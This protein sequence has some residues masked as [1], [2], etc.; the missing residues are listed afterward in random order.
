[1]TTKTTRLTRQAAAERLQVSESTLDRMVRRGDL[2]TEKEKHGSR[3]KIWVLLDE[4]SEQSNDGTDADG[5]E[6]DAYSRRVPADKPEYSPDRVDHAD[7]H[8]LT[9]LKTEVRNL[10]ELADYRG[11]LLKDAEWRYQE[12][13]LQLKLSQETSSTLARALPESVGSP[14]TGRTPRR[15]WWPFGQR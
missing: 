2:P 9:A 8:E 6:N 7:D 3:Y 1:M 5:A 15:R 10:R 12:L 4:G 11:E 13:L 14:N